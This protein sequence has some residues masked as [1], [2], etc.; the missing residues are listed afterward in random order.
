MDN[1]NSAIIAS[2]QN[3]IT[4]DS[5]DMTD[6]DLKDDSNINL[7]FDTY[8]DDSS[9][10]NSSNNQTK[11]DSKDY[12]NIDNNK[13]IKKNNNIINKKQINNNKF[14]RSDKMTQDLQTYDTSNYDIMLKDLMKGTTSDNLITK[15]LDSLTVA[16]DNKF[17]FADFY[18]ENSDQIAK[19]RK[20]NEI[21]IYGS[22]MPYLNAAER[23][24]KAYYDEYYARIKRTYGSTIDLFLLHHTTT[25]DGKDVHAQMV[26]RRI[27]ELMPRYDSYNALSR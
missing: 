5:E 18:N 10:N 24:M 2:D 15:L 20:I 17:K 26:V 11:D 14:I 23:A 25:G 16:T 4:V 27:D 6:V 13:I 3:I 22:Q 12:A 21:L 9:K 19:W 7:E 8:I 1:D